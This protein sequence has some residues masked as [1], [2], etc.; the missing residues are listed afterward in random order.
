MNVS[1]G[2]SLYSTV[3]LLRVIFFL[4]FAVLLETRGQ[5]VHSKNGIRLKIQFCSRRSPNPALS[6]LPP[7]EHITDARSISPRCSRS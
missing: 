6:F 7:C 1:T 5:P 2:L 3:A 4:A